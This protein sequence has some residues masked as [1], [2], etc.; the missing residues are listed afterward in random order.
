[1]KK[2]HPRNSRLF[3]NS[4]FFLAAGFLL[5]LLL[6]ACP[7]PAGENTAA[8]QEPPETGTELPAAPGLPQVRPGNKK[9]VLSWDEVPGAGSYEV[10]CGETEPGEGASPVQTVD[11]PAATVSGLANGTNYYVRLRAKNSSGTGGF[12]PSARGTPALQFPPPSLVRGNGELLVGW[13]AEEGIDY[14]VWYGASGNTGD[15]VQWNGPI[16]RSGI[17]AGTTITGL[18]NGT[19]CHVWIR[20]VNNGTPGDFGEETAE[21]PEAPKSV[22]EGLVY[23]PGGTL[24]GSDSYAITVTVP[25]DPAYTNHGSSFVKRGVFVQGRSVPI[26]S[27]AMAKYETTQGLWHT[28]QTWALEHGYQFQGKK[29]ALSAAQ[30]PVAGISWRDAIVWCNAYSEMQGL[31][32]VYRDSGGNVLK[33]STNAAAAACDGALMDK[34]RSGYRL[35]TQAEREFA[36][37]GGNPGLG[38]WMYMYAGSNTADDVAWHHGNSAYQTK[39]AGTKAPNRL[40]IYDLSGNVQEWCWDW[41]NY[42]VTVTEATPPDGAAYSGTPPLANQKAFNGG[43]VGSNF[44]YSCVAYSWGSLPDYKDN[45]IGFRVVRKP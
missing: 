28:V 39:D 29:S 41:M 3:G 26:P 19:A 30:K 23:I 40:G 21:T 43:G 10:Y 14:Q 45:Y 24:S 33:D 20:P 37:R 22:E 31:E 35:P 6:S 1:V 42:A 4:S 36:A 25:D 2:N 7:Q 12:G 13:A 9:L 38:D 16:A 15:A 44:T 32:P 18:V 8:G 5:S 11:V 17:V 27:F 34:A